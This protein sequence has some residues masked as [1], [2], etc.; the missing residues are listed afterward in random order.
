MGFLPVF[1]AVG[2]K[3]KSKRIFRLKVTSSFSNNFKIFVLDSLIG[4]FQLF[5]LRNTLFIRVIILNK[6]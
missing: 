1:S 5:E 2:F 4:Y 3:I 6:Y